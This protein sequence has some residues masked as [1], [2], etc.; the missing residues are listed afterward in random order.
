MDFIWLE[1][2]NVQISW[3]RKNNNKKKISEIESSEFSCCCYLPAFFRK[4]LPQII[5]LILVYEITYFISLMYIHFN[6]RRK[7]KV[8]E[9]LRHTQF[10]VPQLRPL[11]NVA[12]VWGT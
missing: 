9:M 8:M 5:S 10:T 7:E 12:F 1:K 2:K 3:G 6:A 4:L 11:E